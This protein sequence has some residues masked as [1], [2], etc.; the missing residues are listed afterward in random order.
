MV[1][2]VIAILYFVIGII[3]ASN[4]GYFNHVNDLLD[5]LSAI[6]A[7][8]LWPLVA[9]GINVHIG[10]VANELDKKR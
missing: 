7:V 4:H 6:L 2:K 9:L 5:V 10:H 8:L 1:G 3:L